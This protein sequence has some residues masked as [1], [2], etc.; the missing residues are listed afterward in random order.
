[1]R[2]E[3]SSTNS[4]LLVSSVFLIFLLLLTSC[5]KIEGQDLFEEGVAFA[6]FDAN[7]KLQIGETSPEKTTYLYAQK[8]SGFSNRDGNIYP[9][10]IIEVPEINSNRRFLS[11]VIKT[12]SDS[13]DALTLPIG[14]L[15]AGT[16]T[17]KITFLDK[18]TNYR[19]TITRTLT[20]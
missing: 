13:L 10:V 12:P 5:Q 19:E 20:I 4:I 15:G 7:K 16:F 3:K 11:T 17:V 6:V 9:E 2:Q 18:Y 8:I 1:M 14:V